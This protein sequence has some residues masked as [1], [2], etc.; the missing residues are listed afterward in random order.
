[1]AV[2]SL[3]HV[4]ARPWLVSEAAVGWWPC[5]SS[6]GGTAGAHKACGLGVFGCYH[7][8]S[9]A[10]AGDGTT[11]ASPAPVLL[12]GLF[13]AWAEG[14]GKAA[15]PSCKTHLGWGL[16]PSCSISSRVPQGAWWQLATPRYPLP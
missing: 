16:L 7:L 4:S 9:C 12:G 11:C 1:M 14:H 15:P 5:W 13:W 6:A 3:S 2:Q 10:P 8:G